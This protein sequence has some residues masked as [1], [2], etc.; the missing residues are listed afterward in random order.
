MIVG[1][2]SV[3]QPYLIQANNTGIFL[4]KSHD[5]RDFKYLFSTIKRAG[6]ATSKITISFKKIFRFE[7]TVKLYAYL[8]LTYRTTFKHLFDCHVLIPNFKL[9]AE[10]NDSLKCK[11]KYMTSAF[12]VWS[13]KRTDKNRKTE[14]GHLK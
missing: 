7:M 14:M 10:S 1:R 13:G 5:I 2:F 4:H 9:N 8:C 3:L 6:L 11:W 12:S